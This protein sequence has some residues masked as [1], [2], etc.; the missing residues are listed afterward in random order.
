VSFPQT[1]GL[2]FKAKHDNWQVTRF[3]SLQFIIRN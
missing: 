3:Q 1:K 2:C